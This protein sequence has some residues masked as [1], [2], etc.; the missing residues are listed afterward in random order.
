MC[1]VDN[2][3]A[4]LKNMRVKK[5][6]RVIRGDREDHKGKGTEEKVTEKMGAHEP[7]EEKREKKI[8]NRIYFLRIHLH[9]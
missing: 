4:K 3:G 9:T 7:R 5:E 2:R 8:A 6:I 1:F